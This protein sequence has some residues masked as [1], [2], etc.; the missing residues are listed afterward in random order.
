MRPWTVTEVMAEPGDGH[1]V[2]II[3]GDAE[4]NTSDA[5]LVFDESSM[6]ALSPSSVVSCSFS[7]GFCAS[8]RIAFTAVFVSLRDLICEF[9]S[10][11]NQSKR[12]AKEG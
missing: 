1:T 12:L 5:S 2:D 10:L 11:Q 9:W 4:L 7:T 6:T 3:V 8:P